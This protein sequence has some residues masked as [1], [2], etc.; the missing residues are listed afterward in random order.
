MVVRLRSG[1]RIVWDRQVEIFNADALVQRVV[2]TTAAETPPYSK[3]DAQR[4]ARVLVRAA[5]VVEQSDDLSESREWARSFFQTAHHL[6]ELH[7][8]STA[9]GRYAALCAL[10]D[11]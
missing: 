5:E 11:W 10:R 6:D 1:T 3:A 2:L 7:D 8:M 4:I 9:A